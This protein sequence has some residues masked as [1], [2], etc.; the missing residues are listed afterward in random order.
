MTYSCPECGDQFELVVEKKVREKY[1]DSKEVTMT[2]VHQHDEFNASPPVWRAFVRESGERKSDISKDIEEKNRDMQKLTRQLKVK[3]SRAK[4]SKGP[5]TGLTEEER[6][7]KIAQY[8][9]WAK[10]N[11]K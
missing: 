8:N 9:E 2:L 11:V 4:K 10:E 7:A 1:L 3:E 6:Q 5:I